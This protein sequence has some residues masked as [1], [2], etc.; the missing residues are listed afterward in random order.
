MRGLPG[1][2]HSGPAAKRLVPAHAGVTRVVPDPAKGS[3]TRPRTCGGYPSRVFFRAAPKYSSPHMR[4]LP[5]HLPREGEQSRPR[6]CGGYPGGSPLFC[7]QGSSSPHM[8]GLPVDCRHG[9]DHFALVPAHAGVPARPPSRIRIVLVPVHA[10]VTR[11]S[12]VRHSRPHARPRTCGGY[13]A[14]I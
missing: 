11:R 3:N 4:G 14:S 2:D 7:C 1:R 13:P 10:G 9:R 5:V 8:R 6:T 12:N